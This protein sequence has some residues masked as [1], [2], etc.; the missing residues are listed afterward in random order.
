MCI[1]DRDCGAVPR[2]CS[3]GPASPYCPQHGP[4]VARRA[5]PAAAPASCYGPGQ[6]RPGSGRPQLPPGRL[7]APA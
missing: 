5:R 3:S 6:G 2:A 7:C 4:R 1:R